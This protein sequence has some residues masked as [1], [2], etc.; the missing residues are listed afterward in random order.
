MKQY[1]KLFSFD[2]VRLTFEDAAVDRIA[3]MAYERKTGARG[4]RSI[5]EKTMMDV[6]YQIPSDDSISECVITDAS[7][8]GTSQPLLVHK[9]Q[10]RLKTAK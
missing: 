6:M 9:E 5:M 3:A 2:D 8:E 4:L 7:V 1:Q 10:K